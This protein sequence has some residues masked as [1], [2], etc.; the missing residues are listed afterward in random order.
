MNPVTQLFPRREN[1]G[2]VHKTWPLDVDR[3]LEASPGAG[4]T[5]SR[6]RQE[7]SEMAAHFPRWLLT[8]HVC[9][10]VGLC[11]RCKGMLVFDRGLRCVNCDLEARKLPGNARLAWFG[12]MPPIGIDGLTRVKEGL[13]AAS[14]AQHV[15]GRKD[16]L[17]H[18]LLVPLLASYPAS[19]PGSP[20]EVAYLPGFFRIRG[21]PAE[22][23]SHVYHMFD[24]GLMCLF[25]PGQWRPEMTCR[26]ALQQ[27]AYAHVVKLLNYANGK[28][29]AFSI[30]T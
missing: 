18:Y 8:L 29:D 17:G 28:L 26:E 27:R 15:V 4:L 10:D 16:G 11:A 20:V 7:A 19:F 6:L 23:C 13:L 2:L 30:V 9:R 25:A 1:G 3:A 12:L 24:Q 14:P 21:V 22:R 5:A